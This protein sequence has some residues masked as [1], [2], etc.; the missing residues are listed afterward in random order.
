MSWVILWLSCAP[1]EAET[2]DAVA[3][4]AWAH[5][6][7]T[8]YC[9]ACHAAAS[10]DRHGAPAGVVL[11]EEAQ[12]RAWASRIDARVLVDGTMPLGGGVPP[13]ELERLEAWLACDA[14]AP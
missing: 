8:T 10:V 12:A 3:W 7:F 1:V 14:G 5:G 13:E 9:G 11:D 2:C 4:D 6:F